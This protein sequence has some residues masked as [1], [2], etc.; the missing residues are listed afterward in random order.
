MDK[1]RKAAGHWKTKYDQLVDKESNGNSSEDR[2]A[3]LEK[4]LSEERE[5]VES[6]KADVASAR[7]EVKASKSELESSCEEK[8]KAESRA[9][10]LEA[11]LSDTKGASDLS[12][13]MGELQSQLTAAEEKMDKFR[14]AAA[15][16]KTKHDGLATGGG[17]KE[18]VTESEE[19]GEVKRKN[20]DLETRLQEAEA[21]AAKFRNA[22]VHWKLKFSETETKLHTDNES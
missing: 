19:L 1:F 13:Q 20:L 12:S 3:E 18:Y 6:L 15:H 2:I 8:Q 11:Q 5:Q 21:K 17:D 7:E 22:A 9:A 4:S 10:E 14:K 16:W